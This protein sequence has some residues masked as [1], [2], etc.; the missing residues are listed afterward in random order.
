MA[1]TAIL[2]CASCKTK[3]RIMLGGPRARCGQCK[4]LFTP[5]ELAKAVIEAPPPTNF[6]LEPQDDAVIYVCKDEENCGW[7]GEYDETDEDD[8]GKRICPDCG[9]RVRREDD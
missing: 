5:P 6:D 1:T 2:T 7:E 9:K 4:H 8:R 3:N